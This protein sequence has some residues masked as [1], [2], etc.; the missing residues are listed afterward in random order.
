[1][2]AI[3]L[4][5]NKLIQKSTDS[6][7]EASV[8]FAVKAKNRKK[9]AKVQKFFTPFEILKLQKGNKPKDNS[10]IMKGFNVPNGYTLVISTKSTNKTLQANEYSGGPYTYQEVA[11]NQVEGWQLVPD[12][13]SQPV[14]NTDYFSQSQPEP[15][16]T[17]NSPQDITAMLKNKAKDKS[18]Q[19]PWDN[20]LDDTE[21]PVLTEDDIPD[22]PFEDVWFGINPVDHSA[23]QHLPNE[24]VHEGFDD[25]KAL[26]FLLPTDFAAPLMDHYLGGD[27]RGDSSGNLGS[28]LL[29]NFF[30]DKQHGS[31]G[32]IQSVLDQDP[33]MLLDYV[34]SIDPQGFSNDYASMSIDETLA[35]MGYALHTMKGNTADS[36]NDYLATLQDAGTQGIEDLVMELSTMKY[37]FDKIIIPIGAW[38]KGSEDP[39]IFHDLLKEITTEHYMKNK[40]DEGDVYT[41]LLSANPQKLE[42][43]MAPAIVAHTMI[44]KGIA[45]GKKPSEIL[46]LFTHPK[47]NIPFQMKN[48][49]NAGKVPDFSGEDTKEAYSA[50]ID[51]YFDEL[52]T[53]P[54]VVESFIQML[55]THFE[56]GA[57]NQVDFLK[58]N[59]GHNPSNF[60]SITAALKDIVDD[61][62]E[63]Y[64]QLFDPNDDKHSEL[65][66]A[67]NHTESII[68]KKGTADDI[69]RRAKARTEIMKKLSSPD[70]PV[71]Q[72][73]ARV[74]IE[75]IGNDP[76]ISNMIGYVEDM[77]DIIHLF[78]APYQEMMYTAELDY[79]EPFIT[80]EVLG[81]DDPKEIDAAG[82]KHIF[83]MI[84]KNI[85]PGKTPSESR[86]YHLLNSC[87]PA[88]LDRLLH[89]S[90][91]S[92]SV[93]VGATFSGYLQSIVEDS[94]LE[95]F[96][97]EGLKEGKNAVWAWTSGPLGV[98]STTGMAMKYHYSS[99]MGERD[100]ELEYGLQKRKSAWQDHHG[101]DYA[102]DYDKIIETAKKIGPVLDHLKDIS[103]QVFDATIHDGNKGPIE[104][105]RQLYRGV[106]ITTDHPTY[107]DY[108]DSDDFVKNVTP[109]LSTASSFSYERSVAEDFADSQ[110]SEYNAV[111]EALATRDHALIDCR[112]M[113]AQSSETVKLEDKDGR[114]ARLYRDHTRFNMFTTENE[115]VTYS[116]HVNPMR[117][118]HNTRDASGRAKVKVR[119][120]KS[121][122]F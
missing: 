40:L 14:S 97:D 73:M 50:A 1:M 119:L 28:L 115:L 88:V 3:K 48:I 67:L 33:Y 109:T 37:T 53:H 34:D 104:G 25:D 95:K 42:I 23:N 49:M 39:Y 7:K 52:T 26:G 107:S 118:E 20:Q 70:S 13:S 96:G 17:S 71:P 10:P 116:P 91:A 59:V 15:K 77:D 108:K 78:P 103:Q 62:S 90:L 111:V 43:I 58:Y 86:L 68:P 60:H 76:S 31:G 113:I 100:P 36:F 61:N 8:P 65:I 117:Y 106:F 79:D 105:S 114:T 75:A 12:Q 89:S 85:L 64:T 92:T 63:S 101:D 74:L 29:M 24:V 112:L 18:Y 81:I 72:S 16:A 51:D 84:P 94:L 35:R 56:K 2:A 55:A 44:E 5:M 41:A 82:L 83:S 102:P 30:L 122:N 21:D 46:Q 9:P 4:K 98:M 19:F 54:E 38:I 120:D 99:S 80:L 87:E 22:D 121:L 6:P 11:N 45:E 110:S 27:L 66:V 57:V 69:Q 32:I 47:G 93:S